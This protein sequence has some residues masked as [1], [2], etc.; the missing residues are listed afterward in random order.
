MTQAEASEE[1][2]P[3][4]WVFSGSVEPVATYV[5]YGRLGNVI[6]EL[7]SLTCNVN[8]GDVIDRESLV[9]QIVNEVKLISLPVSTVNMPSQSMVTPF[10]E[11]LSQN[12]ELVGTVQVGELETNVASMFGK[13]VPI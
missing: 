13:V 8:T 4:I 12:D 3:S 10:K 5:K 11:E 7:Q 6:C 1:A 9:N 2:E